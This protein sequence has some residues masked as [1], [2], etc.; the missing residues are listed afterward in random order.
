MS[1]YHCRNDYQFTIEYL[2]SHHVEASVFFAWLMGESG[3]RLFGLGF[4]RD[5]H[6]VGMSLWKTL[7]AMHLHLE[8]EWHPRVV[9]VDLC[10]TI[11]E[12]NPQK[13]E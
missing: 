1:D 6:R 2:S 13:R 12:N 4:M 8:P 11:E 5:L 10:H 7:E 9:K 3:L